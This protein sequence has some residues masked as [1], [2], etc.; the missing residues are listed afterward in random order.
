MISLMNGKKL[1]IIRAAGAVNKNG[2]PQVP[3]I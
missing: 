3:V 1:V 2:H